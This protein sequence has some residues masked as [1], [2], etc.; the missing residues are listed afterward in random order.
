MI[1]RYLSAVLRERGHEPVI[2]THDELDQGATPQ[3]V[4]FYLSGLTWDAEKNPGDAQRIHVDVPRRFLE[5]CRPERFLYASSTRVYDDATSTQEKQIA[6]QRDQGVYARTKLQGEQVT[7][8][9]HEVNRVLRL[10][11]IVGLSERAQVFHTDIL[12]QAATTG[13]VTLHSSPAS[14]KDYLP[15]ADAASLIADIAAGSRHRIYNVAAGV[16]TSHQQ[17]LEAIKQHISDLHIVVDKDAPTIS[18][19][20]IDV[21]R[22]SSEFAFR[23]G[24]VLE[25]VPEWLALFRKSG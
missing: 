12:R 6:V 20:E 24:S 8:D 16:N 23:P 9:A 11:N 17:W 5:R 18:V 10:S 3:G 13:T 4:V 7:L 19:P 25:S 1:G 22:I 2:L 21:S 14:S 15:A